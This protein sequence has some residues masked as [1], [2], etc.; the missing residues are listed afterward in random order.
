MAG[1]ASVHDA[2][3]KDTNIILYAAIQKLESILEFILKS[4]IGVM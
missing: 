4:I 3:R 2:G 1:F